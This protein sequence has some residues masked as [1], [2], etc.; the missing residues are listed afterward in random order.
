MVIG[1][2]R[3]TKYQ[4]P[5]LGLLSIVAL[6]LSVGHES[7]RTLI[8][9]TASDVRMAASFAAEKAG[10]VELAETLAPVSPRKA[11]L[12][13]SRQQNNIARFVVGQ[14]RLEMSK[15]REY[16]DLAFKAAKAYKVDPHLVLAIMSIESSF[17]ADAQ[18]NKGAQGLMQ[19]LTRVHREKFAPFGGTAAAYD[20][21]SN[22]K[23]GA[24]ILREYISRSGSEEQ[25]LKFY[26]GAALLSDDG[27]YGQKVL[28]QKARI[29]A[30]ALGQ[31]IPPMPA[32]LIAKANI[33][34]GTLKTNASIDFSA[35][36]TPAGSVVS[37]SPL[38][39]SGQAE[40]GIAPNE[41]KS[42]K[43]T[44]PKL[45]VLIADKSTDI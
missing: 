1:A 3:F 31:A 22:I 8:V 41:V 7:T 44:E 9:E 20:P 26:V 45:D 28:G 23:V 10:S 27:G 5:V 38:A 34:N 35:D 13:L 21:E 32:I 16:V 36:D 4:A 25:A 18:S 37:T 43:L 12:A 17:D 33:G 15:A 42:N 29:V 14:Y 6:G 30:A 19:V 39:L 11:E 40:N 2:C 24:Q